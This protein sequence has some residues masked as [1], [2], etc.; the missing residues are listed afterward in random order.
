M[1]VVPR[2]ELRH[3]ADG[4]RLQLDTSKEALTSAPHFK[5]DQWPDLTQP[6][7][8]D[9][10]YRAYKVDPYFSTNEMTR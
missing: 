10:V 6:T 9:G 3:S 7:Y 1:S 2:T 8:A 4:T 5:A